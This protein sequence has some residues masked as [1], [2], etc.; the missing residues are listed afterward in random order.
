MK[1]WVNVSA[2]FVHD[3]DGS[4]TTGFFNQ[5]ATI[6]GK[7]DIGDFIGA[8]ACASQNPDSYSIGARS[9][10]Q[11][12]SIKGVHVST[13]GYR[14]RTGRGHVELPPPYN[15]SFSGLINIQNTD[16]V[17]FKYCVIAALHPPASKPTRMVYYVAKKNKHFYAKYDWT[18]VKFPTGVA[19][20]RRFENNNPGIAISCFTLCEE[21]KKVHP[22][23]ISKVPSPEEPIHIL[24][25]KEH[26][27]LISNLDRLLNSGNKD[28]RHY[29]ER[30]LHAFKSKA[31]LL[32]HA[33]QCAAF[34]PMRVS[35]P[36]PGKDG[37][38]STLSFK[39][40]HKIMQ[41]PMVIFADSKA[42]NHETHETTPSGKTLRSSDH[43]CV[44][45]RARV[46]SKV[47]GYKTFSFQCTGVD[48][49][50][51]F[52][53]KLYELRPE[54]TKEFTKN[55][56]M[57]MTANDEKGH[58]GADVCCECKKAFGS[59]TIKRKVRHHYHMTGEYIGACHA[60]CNLR[61]GLRYVDIPVFFHNGKGYD[62]H[63]I[64][65]AISRLEDIKSAKLSVIPG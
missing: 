33:S 56:P 16:D 53:R 2:E 54:L 42:I 17:C 24:F 4:T 26:W 39:G 20:I 62:N 19:D 34:K 7:A 27:I 48:A 28:Q 21:T 57:K 59:C 36:Q 35:V 22:L 52:L 43:R 64:I 5:K 29:C 1:A 15:N 23:S 63:L 51:Q 60:D 31:K 14:V 25:Y 58:A 65:Q 8:V 49:A 40:D 32:Q 50:D 18:G 11:M 61:M 41:V 37:K 13:N 12:R 10:W 46:E 55:T 6:H 44:S 38:A 30:C 3:G 47:A 9:G 45:I